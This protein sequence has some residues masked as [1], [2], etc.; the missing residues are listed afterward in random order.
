MLVVILFFG[1]I[2]DKMN[3]FSISYV[4][5]TRSFATEFMEMFIGKIRMKLHFMEVVMFI[6]IIDSLTGNGTESMIVAIVTFIE[7]LCASS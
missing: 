7:Y 4:N 1:T 5:R 3:M 6:S 2:L